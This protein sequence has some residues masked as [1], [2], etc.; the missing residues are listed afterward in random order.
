MQP[1]ESRYPQDW[2][3]IADKDLDRADRML[4]DND[5]EAAAFYVQQ[6]LEKYLKAFLL[7]KGWALR[8]IHDLE[9]LLNDALPH[10]SSLHEFRTLCQRATGYY[11]VERYPF[12]APTGLTSEKVAQSLAEAKRF[13][14]RLLG[15]IK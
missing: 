5:A 8:R 15:Q 13:I 1:E 6:A 12:S 9:V 4:A 2:K 7:S 14:E 3:R 10:D 11:F